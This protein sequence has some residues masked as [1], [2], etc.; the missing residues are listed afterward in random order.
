MGLPLEVVRRAPQCLFHNYYLLLRKHI[1]GKNQSLAKFR[2]NHT[3][4][5]HGAGK[6]VIKVGIFAAIVG[7]MFWV[8]NFFLGDKLSVPEEQTELHT[9]KEVPEAEE[10]GVA[11]YFLPAGN[12]GEIIKHRHYAL[13]YSEE[14][15]QAEW[16]AYELT[17]EQLSRP[18]V[19]RTDDFRPDPKVPK[20]SASTRDYYGTGYSRGHLIPAADRAFSEKAMSETFYMSNISPQIRNFNGGVWRE[21]EENVRGWA[22]K[23]RHLYIVTGPVLQVGIR[24]KI[25]GNQVSVP[26]TYYKVILDYTEPEIKAVA[27]LIPNEKSTRPLE[28]YAVPIDIVEE[29]TGIDFFPRL[30]E[31][32]EEDELES[33]YD[34]SLWPTDKRKF[35]ER[36]EEWNEK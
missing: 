25:G 15:E 10:R 14:H 17:R 21:L 11:D 30:L 9:E 19:E 6:G 32:A 31:G 26:D 8:F 4:Q 2:S 13:A 18:W 12:S 7:G 36:V 28:D 35:R 22:R 24:E 20:A 34:I 29:L 33:G 23:F 16:V 27:F 1:F 3:R 5:K